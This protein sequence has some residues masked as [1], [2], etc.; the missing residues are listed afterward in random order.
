[1]RRACYSFYLCLSLLLFFFVSD[2]ASVPLSTSS[3][4]I[5]DKEGRRVKLACVNWPSH[6]EPMLAEG[7]GKQTLDTITKRVGSMGF[8]CVRLTW[9]TFMVTNES[10]SSLTVQQSLEALNLS[11]SIGAIQVNNPSLLNLTLIQAFEAVVSSLRDN[12]VM[13][14]LD[15]HIS[16]PGWCCSNSDGNGFF[17]DKYFDPDV[18]IQGLTKM[19]TM[20]NGTS[21][22]VGMS[23][24]NE[25]RG[26][27][28]NVDDW[29]RYMQKGA[30]AVH[31]GNPDVLVIL[32]GMSFDNDLSFLTRSPVNVSFS[33]KLVFEL[34]WY[35]FSD[36]EAWRSGN[37]NDVC[38]RITGNVER[39]AGFLLDGGSPLLLSE[40]GVDNRGGN[41]NDDRY[42][43]CVAG[44]LADWDLDW[45]LWTLQGSYYLRQGVFGLDEVY[46]VL[47]WDWCKD[48]NTSALS[49]IQALQPPF[50]GPGVSN[51]PPYTIIFHPSTGLCVLKKSLMEPTLELGPCNN[52]EAWTY[53]SQHA[54][55]LKDT[56]LC[57]K[58]EGS[59]KPAKLG[60]VCTDSSSKWELISDSKM[61]ISSCNNGAA[62]SL[63][64]DVGTDGRSIV[65]NPCECLSR[66][67]DCD[68]ESQWFRLVSSTRSIASRIPLRQLPHQ[69]RRWKIM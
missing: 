28:Q 1:M 36:G 43:G 68:P 53:T 42:F 6:L 50:Q 33:N 56:L 61:H 60:I 19:A 54:L 32:S 64:L 39:K 2:V 37:A 30:E 52:T 48:R 3:R 57:L 15:N 24:R 18:W 62:G 58:A 47:G 17:G 65:T 63:C 49:R 45:A 10:L 34:H 13:V 59:G 40:F 8:N 27:K 12:N 7:L 69:F 9:A 4:W 29:Y 5:V 38:G 14:I 35:S 16:K 51:L 41:A 67:Q 20:F 25:L 23:L 55:M 21:N 66:R 22:V 44:V 11:E 26:P 46:G 31:A